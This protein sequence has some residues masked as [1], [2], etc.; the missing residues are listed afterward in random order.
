MTNKSNKL[1]EDKKTT[2]P[3]YIAMESVIGAVCLLATKSNTH[4]HLFASDYEW[5]ILPA[6]RLRQ[7]SLL[8]NKKNEPMAFVSWAL[9]SDNVEKRLLDGILKLKPAEWKSGNKIYIIDVISPF[10]SELEIMKQLNNGY[11]KDSEAK[12]LI[13]KKDSKGFRARTLKEISAEVEAGKNS[14]V[15]DGANNTKKVT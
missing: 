5:L 8:R 3:N 7:F 6:I 10:I 1:E 4:R 12:I 15:S 2:I 14:S 13:P 11:L 9:V